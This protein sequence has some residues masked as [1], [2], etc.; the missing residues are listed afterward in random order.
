MYYGCRNSGNFGEHN[1][2]GLMKEFCF[3]TLHALG[4]IV[5]TDIGDFWL[6]PPCFQASE[7][8]RLLLETFMP[9]RKGNLLLR[10]PL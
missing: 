2:K 3:V 1:A 8:E 6:R 5:W 10:N 4:F 9:E 7:T